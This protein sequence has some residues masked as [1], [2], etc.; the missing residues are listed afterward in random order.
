MTLTYT[1]YP[2]FTVLDSDTTIPAGDG[3]NH[4]QPG[5]RDT[6]CTPNYRTPSDPETHRVARDKR[7]AGWVQLP[8]MMAEHIILVA[9]IACPMMMWLR[10]YR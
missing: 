5:T 6:R 1:S 7:C 4:V 2:W 3:G 9:G 8:R 10:Q